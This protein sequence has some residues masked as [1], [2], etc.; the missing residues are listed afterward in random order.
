[1]QLERT[2][3]LHEIDAVLLGSAHW[4][5]MTCRNWIDW[6]DYL[7][8]IE[9]GCFRTVEMGCCVYGVADIHSIHRLQQK[10][11]AMWTALMMILLVGVG[12]VVFEDFPLRIHI[13]GTCCLLYSVAVH[14]RTI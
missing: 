7:L 8:K 9:I 5:L 12:A 13:F 11:M 1:M 14:A 6:I 2:V 4:I 10:K 3:L